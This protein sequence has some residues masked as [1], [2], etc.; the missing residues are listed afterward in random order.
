MFRSLAK[1][2]TN[3]KKLP[4]FIIG[5]ALVA[6]TTVV[7]ASPASA[8]GRDI[9]CSVSGTFSI[10]DNN[11]VNSS[12]SDCSGAVV[13]PADVTRIGAWAFANRHITSLDFETGSQL[14][15]IDMY[16]AEFSDL[17]TIHLPTGLQTVGHGAFTYAKIT[18]ISI[19]GTV[20]TITGSPF[21]S[22][23]LQTVIFEERVTPIINLSVDTFQDSRDLSS[24]TFRGPIEVRGGIRSPKS[25]EGL[26]WAGWSKS[27]DG[28]VV[29]FPLSI[30]ESGGATLYP[31]WVPPFV[32]VFN[33]SLGGT[34]RIVDH[35]V[36]SSTNDCVGEVV[37][38]ADAIEIGSWAFSGKNLT[39]MSFAAGS[40]LTQISNYAFEYS[41]LSS[42]TL[43]AGLTSIGGGAFT[44]TKITSIVLPSGLKSIGDAAFYGTKITSISIPGNVETISGSPFRNSDLVTATFEP[45]I[46]SSFNLAGSTFQNASNLTSVIFSGPVQ[47]SN[48]GTISKADFNW[49]GWSTSPG[50][51]VI[52]FPFSVTDSAGVTLYPKWT[53][54]IIA[55]G[56]CSLGGTFRIVDHIIKSS[57]DDCAGVVSVPAD[58]TEIGYTAFSGKNV[59]S[60]NI[61]AGSQLTRIAEYAF[62]FTP[63][64]SINLPNGFKSI[65]HGAFTFAKLSTI[66]IPGTVEAIEGSPFYGAALETVVFEPRVAS[67]LS[68]SNDA[69]IY[70][71][72]LR[73]VTFMGPINFDSAPFGHTRYA[74]DWLGWSTSLGGPIVTYPLSVTDPAG[75]VL[76]PN[77]SP[78]TYTATYDSRGGT[79][80]APGSIVGGEI[81][82]PVSPTRAGYTFDGWFDS[83]NYWDWSRGPVTLWDQNNGATFYAKWIPDTHVVNFNSKGGSAVS[84]GSFVTDGE[85]SS[86]PEA[87]VLDGYRLGGWSATDGGSEISFPYAPGGIQDVTLYAV[88]IRNTPTI[89]SGSTPD[90]QVVSIPA[91]LTEAVVPAT[92]SLPGIKFGLPGTGGQVIATVAP[93]V[94]P[95]NAAHTPFTVNG[96]TVIVDIEITGVTGDVTVCIDGGPRDHI[97]HY[98]GGAWVDLPQRT[99]VNGQVCGVTSSYSPFTAATPLP[100]KPYVMERPSISG[101]AQQDTY[102]SSTMGTW[103]ADPVATKSVQW[104]RCDKNVSAGLT[105][106]TAAMKCKKIAGATKARYKVS[107][108]DQGKYLSSLVKAT[109]TVGSATLTTKAIRVPLATQ[110]KLKT[111]AKL[112][113]TAAKGK[114]VTLTAGKWTANPVAA[115][116]QQWYRCEKSVKAGLDALATA[117]KCTKVPGATGLRYRVVTADLDM[118]LTAVITAKNSQGVVVIT[119]KSVHVPGTKP[120]SK[121]SPSISGA[122]VLDGALQAT[123]GKWTAV[124]EATTSVQWYRCDASVSAGRG[125]LSTSSCTKIAGATGSRYKVTVADQ[126][127]RLAVEVKAKNSY[128]NNS[129]H[130]K[131]TAQVN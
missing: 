55:T 46:A 27:V 63:L 8:A 110:P 131:S 111:L 82:F 15:A 13:I 85:I 5:I 102:L 7:A 100:Y 87:P 78:R 4:S 50:G 91:G 38:P 44:S 68:T 28:P 98:T 126:G 1:S 67:Q 34:F 93:T 128:G 71:R 39:S 104:Y 95:A 108:A 83:P 53:A 42:I 90:S 18:T 49:T 19:P 24:V 22:T 129:A 57:T 127:K 84:A 103:A 9:A 92:A 60:V 66:S 115:T 31:V 121:T 76:Y 37:V 23:N 73:S 118:Y 2:H 36:T 32:E 106:F 10:N 64:T 26:K 80:V 20:E 62:E 120:T 114:Q 105:T 88:W 96:S 75:V 17:A 47:V 61:E 35:V 72:K 109:N 30:T 113:G 125:S 51:S 124:P 41:Q 54:Q 56:N 65:G 81:E 86:A 122:A 112:S 79:E 16:A 3:A 101:N 33:C 77:A 119:A 40:Q 70:T 58:V 59:T 74:Q 45:R 48:L 89:T 43:P 107:L 52:S 94:N 21:N 12:S 130:S 97:Y 116:S 117:A 11:V 29:S 123:D 69:F 6:G 14:V 25:K 99:Y